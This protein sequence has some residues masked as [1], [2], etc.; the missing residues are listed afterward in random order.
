MN[1]TD[2]NSAKI[3]LTDVNF[4]KRLKEYDKNNISERT[5][6]KLKAYID[7]K[8]FRPEIVAKTSKVC[9]SICLWVR[10][11]DTYAKVYKM[12]EPKIEKQREAE[13]QLNEVMALLRRKQDQLALVE[14]KLRKL[15]SVYD[16][17]M[18]EL[19]KLQDTVDLT[20]KR[21]SHANK[22]TTA[23]EDEEIRWGET[24]KKLDGS[25]SQITGDILLAAGC[26]SYLGEF[27]FSL[28]HRPD[29]YFL[30]N[31]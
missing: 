9:K 3:L 5:L 22:L 10:A 19:N 12:V 27:F 1:R 20:A 15:E 31:C 11:I 8:D 13:R 28:K 30:N 7:H 16:Q 18:V 21:L 29:V 14:D 17:S 24:V 25:L 6:Q 26:V 4:L 23:L 2:W